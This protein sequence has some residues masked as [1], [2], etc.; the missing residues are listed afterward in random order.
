MSISL[1]EK[2]SLAQRADGKPDRSLIDGWSGALQDHWLRNYLCVRLFYSESFRAVVCAGRGGCCMGVIWGSSLG[3][4]SL[5][6]GDVKGQRS[7]SDR[8][9]K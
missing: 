9:F 7:E 4:F 5:L 6:K 8:E 2:M 3:F 1:E